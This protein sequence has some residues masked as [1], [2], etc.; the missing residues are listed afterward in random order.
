[1]SI[2]QRIDRLLKRDQMPDLA[3]SRSGPAA[4]PGRPGPEGQT[5]GAAGTATDGGDGA[6]GADESAGAGSPPRAV[7]AELQRR[8]GKRYRRA[9]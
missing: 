9:L 8:G 6:A 5:A 3:P 4:A 1:T 2:E 7:P